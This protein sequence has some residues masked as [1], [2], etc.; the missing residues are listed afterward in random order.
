[1]EEYLITYEYFTEKI[2]RLNQ[3]T[4]ELALEKTYEEK[5]KKLDCLIG[6]KTHTSLSMIVEAGDFE[7]FAKPEKFAAFLG[8]VPSEETSDEKQNR[9]DCYQGRKQPSAQTAY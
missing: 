2:E 8:L 4:E 9:Y 3:R 1:M 5:V 6:V 7:R